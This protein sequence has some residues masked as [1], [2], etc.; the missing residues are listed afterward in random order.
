MLS[1]STAC[2]GP[3]P[4]GC[5]PAAGWGR[6]RPG[7]ARPAGRRWW[8]CQWPRW[9]PARRAASGRWTAARPR[10][11]G[12]C[13]QVGSRAAPPERQCR[14]DCGCAVVG[15][16]PGAYQAPS[17]WPRSTKAPPSPCATA[18]MGFRAGPGSLPHAPAGLTG[19]PMTGSGVIA[20][21]MPGRWAAPPA[22]GRQQGYYVAGGAQYCVSDMWEHPLIR[23]RQQGDPTP[24]LQCPEQRRARPAAAPGAWRG[25]VGALTCARNDAL[26]AAR[27]GA[28]GVGHHA[29][30]RAVGTDHRHFAG[31]AKL[32]QHLPPGGVGVRPL[33]ARAPGGP[34]ASAG[35][36][37]CSTSMLE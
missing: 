19:T 36:K 14:V 31:H 20:A 9:P 10:H 21:T 11:P 15:H 16:T 27:V 28:V 34:G 13:L 7:C 12:G 4:G 17:P 30:G 29:L 18:P 1:P 6:L 2:S 35:S 33:A 23:T 32:L 26:D 24:Q 5:L 8:H 3:G 22:T 25:H 37:A